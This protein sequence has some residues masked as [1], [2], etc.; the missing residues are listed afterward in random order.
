MLKKIGIV[1]AVVLFIVL[2]R[3]FGHYLTLAYLKESQMNFQAIYAQN[4]IMVITAYM[5]IY[6]LVTALSLPGAAVLTL[7]GG[8]LFGLIA[9]TSH[10]IFCEHNRGHSGL[11]SLPFYIKGLGSVKVRGEA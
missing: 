1:A 8:G 9:G 3:Y 6:I 4:S 2:F 5:V 7:A 11:S 10:S